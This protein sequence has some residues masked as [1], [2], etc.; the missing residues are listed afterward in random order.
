MGKPTKKADKAQEKEKQNSLMD[1]VS[2]TIVKSSKNFAQGLVE[3][4]KDSINITIKKEYFTQ[5]DGGDLKNIQKEF[6]ISTNKENTSLLK[7]IIEQLINI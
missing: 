2:N 7:E 1:F 6:K 3:G 5:D 4:E